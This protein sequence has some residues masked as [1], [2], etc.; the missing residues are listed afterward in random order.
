M[1]VNLLLGTM[2]G[3]FFGLLLWGFAAIVAVAILRLIPNGRIK[4]LLKTRLHPVSVYTGPW[5]QRL[6]QRVIEQT[7]KNFVR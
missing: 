1:N 6:R 2:L 5:I 3:P 4:R 7:R